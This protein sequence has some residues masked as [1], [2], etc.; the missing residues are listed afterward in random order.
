MELLWHA[1]PEAGNNKDCG[2]IGF[3]DYVCSKPVT[4]KDSIIHEESGYE[5]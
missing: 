1:V 3:P 2:E 5:A 4:R